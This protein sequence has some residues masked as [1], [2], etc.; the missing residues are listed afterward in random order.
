MTEQKKDYKDLFHFGKLVYDEARARLNSFDNKASSYLSALTILFGLL[1]IALTDLYPK[2]LNQSNLLSCFLFILFLG[3]V[4]CLGAAC[5]CCIYVLRLKKAKIL[6][7]NELVLNEFDKKD[8]QEFYKIHCNHIVN[9]LKDNSEGILEKKTSYLRRAHLW[10]AIA[11][12]GV[13][14]LLIVSAILFTL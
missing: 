12:G 9:I 1:A 8:V 2:L 3:I 4:L 14:L 10:S 11:L 5:F 7:F 6:P 13:V